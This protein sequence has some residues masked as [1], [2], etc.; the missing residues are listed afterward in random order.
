MRRVLEQ[1][2]RVAP[3]ATSVLITGPTGTG[4]ELIAR[5]IHHRSS[6]AGRAFVAIDCAALAPSV[7]ESE[8][9]GHERGAFTGA[10]R[11]RLGAFE[12]AQGATLFIDEV[13][14]L[15]LEAQAKLLR[16]LQERQL[17][18]VGGSATIDTDFRL[19]AASNADLLPRV[20]T[21]TFR[22]DLYHRL[23]VYGVTLP[24]L[25]ERSED[26]P[27]LVSHFIAQKRARLGRPDVMRVSNEAL[28]ALMAYDWPGNVR[29]LENV[30]EAALVECRSDTIEVGHLRYPPHGKRPPFPD[31][32]TPSPGYREARRA[33]I[34]D[35]ERVYL[36]AL[37][38]RFDGRI[39]AAAAAAGITPKHLRTLM[40]R[41]H[42]KR[43]AFRRPP[44]QRE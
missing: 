30:I 17:R 25:H 28:D 40:R 18:R 43:H 26:I 37:L 8:L 2:T 35:F 39:A 1:V 32:A 34:T 15:S 24:P 19:I 33:A 9:F 44:A 16:V 4:K 20:R 22:A 13:G 36:L 21:G 12:L 27:L 6:R 14:N 3:T 7:L 23:A 42:I 5:L 10:E 38:R 31:S 29:E 41:N 11:M